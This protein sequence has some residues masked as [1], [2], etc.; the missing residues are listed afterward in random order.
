MNK[1]CPAI[2]IELLWAKMTTLKYY[3]A[4]LLAQLGGDESPSVDK[5]RAI[6]DSVGIST[7]ESLAAAAI[8]SASQI[9][10]NR[11]TEDASEQLGVV[12]ARK[13]SISTTA[14]PPP[15]GE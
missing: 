4:Y 12:G 3:A 6:L 9:D 15:S 7:D 8:A 1:T 14:D 2:P 11:L 5:I 13:G 10:T